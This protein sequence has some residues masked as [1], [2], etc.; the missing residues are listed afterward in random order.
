MKFEITGDGRTFVSEVEGYLC[1]IKP[2]IA[3]GSLL[4]E[5]SIQSGG[6]WTTR[7]GPDVHQHA[8]DVEL[9]ARDAQEAI[10]A[11]IDEP[12]KHALASL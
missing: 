7:G 5:W 8:K 10:E 3:E 12:P 9:S 1:F 4:W 11:W 6:G 2:I